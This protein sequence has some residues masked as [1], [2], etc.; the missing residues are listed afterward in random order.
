MQ[1]FTLQQKSF[2]LLLALVTIGFGWILAPYGGAVFW[3]V[4][5]A[6]LFAPLNRWLL[7][8]TR[9]KPNLAALITLLSIIFMVILPLSLIAASLVDQAAG[10]YELVQSG[11][12]S[13]GNYFKQVMDA[14]P[15][16]AV[17]LLE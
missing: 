16:W 2:L 7:I 6:I 5:L 3:G 17:N 13:A 12:L 10:V 1:Q 14:L 8:K 11:H 15:K 4:I 9:Q